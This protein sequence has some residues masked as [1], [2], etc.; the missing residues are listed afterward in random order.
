[1]G[2]SELCLG[3]ANGLGGPF[4][5][6][7]ARRKL[8]ELASCAFENEKNGVL[9]YLNESLCCFK[10]GKLLV[11]SSDIFHLKEKFV[12]VEQRRLQ[13]NGKYIIGTAV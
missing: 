12:G 7:V 3:G 6:I 1:M 5:R 10:D 9:M 13:S 11:E 4:V 2:Y 8:V